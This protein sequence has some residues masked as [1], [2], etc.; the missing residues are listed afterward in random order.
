MK[1]FVLIILLIIPTSYAFSGDKN[2][3]DLKY[4]MLIGTPEPTVLQGAISNPADFGVPAA[5]ELESVGGK[6]IGYYFAME[7][8]KNYAILALPDSSDMAAFVYQRMST[9]A[10]KDI[11]VVELIPSDRMIEIFRKADSLKK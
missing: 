8:A 11:E 3:S 7:H 6:L 5:A 1:R 4:Y 9:G 2:T 10:M